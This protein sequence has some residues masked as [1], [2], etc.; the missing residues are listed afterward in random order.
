MHRVGIEL[1]GIDGISEIVDPIEQ[2]R[3]LTLWP[4]SRFVV[5]MPGNVVLVAGNRQHGTVGSNAPFR[6]P[7]AVLPSPATRVVSIFAS[8]WR[9]LFRI[10]VLNV[11]IDTAAGQSL[12]DQ[13]TLD[14]CLF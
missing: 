11:R 5:S 12:T 2:I 13:V 10:H 8:R 3:R 6:S 1:P 7:I 14:G 4:V 9:I